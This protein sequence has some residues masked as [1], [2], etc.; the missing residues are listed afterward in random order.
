MVLGVAGPVFAVYAGALAGVDA[1][2][3]VGVLLLLAFLAVFFIGATSGRFA[4]VAKDADVHVSERALRVDDEVIARSSIESAVVVDDPWFDGV[5]V[6]LLLKHGLPRELKLLVSDPAVAESMVET[7]GL[8]AS[9]ST[10][11][12]IGGRG[13][14]Y[15]SGLDSLTALL[16]VVA[17]FVALALAFVPVLSVAITAGTAL[18]APLFMEL[19][20]TRIIVG[21][22]GVLVRWFGKSRFCRFEDVE[23]IDTWRT[24]IKLLLRGGGTFDVAFC[25]ETQ[26]TRDPYGE[27]RSKIQSLRERIEQAIRARQ[28]SPS[29]NVTNDPYL[30]GTRSPREW[31]AAL[32]RVF[33]PS[34]NIRSNSPTCESAWRVVLDP[35]AREDARV[36]AA[37]AIAMSTD[38]EERAR[39]REVASS[40]VDARVRVALEAAAS[41]DEAALEE[42]MARVEGEQRKG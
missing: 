17:F 7:L 20:R 24:G 22:D 27:I 34:A 30:R 18:L 35:G 36:G 1:F 9:R 15:S 19:T 2:V 5:R 29:A 41:G 14:S 31:L 21:S 23:R 11:S 26:A 13:R 38:A 16:W 4:P 3:V 10:A 32:R 28:A 8:D 39:L 40:L 6:T 12:W 33:E 42:A 37:A 25:S